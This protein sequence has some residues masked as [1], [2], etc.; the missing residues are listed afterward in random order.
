M[1]PENGLVETWE[2]E[3]LNLAYYIYAEHDFG[4]PEAWNGLF[5]DFQKSTD[6]DK[7]KNIWQWFVKKKNSLEIKLD[8]TSEAENSYLAYYICA[9]YDFGALEAW[10]G[11]FSDFRNST[12][13]DKE[14]KT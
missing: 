12:K 4:I 8:G 14:K 6:L 2:A 10:N 5:S 7:E 11:L 9:N 3:N 1:L 13:L